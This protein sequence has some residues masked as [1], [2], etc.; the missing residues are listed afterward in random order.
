MSHNKILREL[1]DLLDIPE[2]RKILTHR[3]EELKLLLSD[4]IGHYRNITGMISPGKR[5]SPAEGVQF[6]LVRLG[7]SLWIPALA[8]LPDQPDS[9]VYDF[10][11]QIVIDYI[12]DF[13]INPGEIK[14]ISILEFPRLKGRTFNLSFEKHREDFITGIISERKNEEDN[15]SKINPELVEDINFSDMELLFHY[16]LNFPFFYKHILNEFKM[17]W[18]PLIDSDMQ[19]ENLS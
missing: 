15:Y 6:E 16:L 1:E 7:D 3:I 8:D 2:F 11:P 9:N 17:M 13:D 12:I 4:D 5:M 10:I 14:M 18:K 19:Q